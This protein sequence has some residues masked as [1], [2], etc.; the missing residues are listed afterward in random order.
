MQ[1]RSRTRH[2][3]NCKHPNFR[4]PGHFVR[5]LAVA[6][7]RGKLIL[8]RMHPIHY[9]LLGSQPSKGIGRGVEEG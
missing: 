9:D 3:L 6:L 8:V 7:A 2:N 1:G 4:P 5:I